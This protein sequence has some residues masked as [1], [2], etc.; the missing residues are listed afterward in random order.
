MDQNLILKEEREM[1]RQSLAQLKLS[2]YPKGPGDYDG[3]TSSWL[4]QW[5]FWFLGWLIVLATFPVSV[6]F[7][8]KVVKE[9]ERA[10][11]FRLGRLIGGG[12]K[13]PGESFL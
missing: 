3:D 6:C 10:V 2:Y 5:G 9:Y 1:R 4:C 8:L 11:I 13:G 7:C 12:S